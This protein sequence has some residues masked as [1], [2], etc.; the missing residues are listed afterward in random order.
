[1]FVRWSAAIAAAVLLSSP[2]LLQDAHA[3]DKLTDP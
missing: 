1:M 2:V 3:A